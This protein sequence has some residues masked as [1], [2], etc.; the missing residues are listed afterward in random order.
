ME[1]W[2]PIAGFEKAYAVSSEGRVKSLSRIISRGWSMQQMPERIM[3]QQEWMGYAV[4]WLR[5]PGINQKCKVHRLVADAFLENP[6]TLAVV[7]HKDRNRKNNRV[8]NLEWASH[9]ENTA[10][11]MAD[12]L[13]KKVAAANPPPYE[14]KE[15]D[16]PW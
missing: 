4:I 13:A 8:E 1:E 10:H 9:K 11:W 6:G 2:R 12:D 5:A 7:N 16:L 15:A 3:L 14:F